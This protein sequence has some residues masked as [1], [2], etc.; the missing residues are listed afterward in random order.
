M[1]GDQGVGEVAPRVR[2]DHG[3]AVT[4]WWTSTST[5][6]ARARWH[7]D[8]PTGV[9][10]GLAPADRQPLPRTLR[11][12]RVPTVRGAL[13]PRSLSSR[14]SSAPVRSRRAGRSRRGPGQQPRVREIRLRQRSRLTPS[15]T[16]NLAVL[17]L[18]PGSGSSR[19]RAAACA[20]AD[21]S[22]VGGP[23]AAGRRREARARGARWVARSAIAHH[24]NLRRSGE[25]PPASRCEAFPGLKSGAVLLECERGRDDH[26]RGW[27]PG[28]VGRRWAKRPLPLLRGVAP[29]DAGLV[30]VKRRCRERRGGVARTLNKISVGS[31]NPR[32]PGALP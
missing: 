10:Q 32:I 1:E 19:V 24:R 21:R 30:I 27:R 15:R 8:H 31:E 7:Q 29:F 3:Q 22:P 9:P 11:R 20:T 2:R 16:G 17:A 26:A 13:Q 12:L 18:E 23:R 25:V 4:R 14:S 6:V 5:S 28:P